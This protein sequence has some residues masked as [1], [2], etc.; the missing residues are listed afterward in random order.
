MDLGRGDYLQCIKA[1]EAGGQSCYE[2]ELVVVESVTYAPRSAYD[3]E[4]D[5]CGPDA[6]AG[7]GLRLQGKPISTPWLFFCASCFKPVYK[8]D[9]EKLLKALSLKPRRILELNEK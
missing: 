5:S 3:I 4:C 1:C 8:P 7:V 2:G 6:C 9:R